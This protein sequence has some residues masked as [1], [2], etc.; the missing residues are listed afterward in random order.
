MPCRRTELNSTITPTQ[1]EVADASQTLSGLAP[2]YEA[3]VFLAVGLAQ[4]GVPGPVSRRTAPG[5][6]LP[7]RMILG[8]TRPTAF[9]GTANPLTS[10]SGRDS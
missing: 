3:Q 8:T 9:T 2:L 4:G 5:S 10:R 6:H 7:R 1:K